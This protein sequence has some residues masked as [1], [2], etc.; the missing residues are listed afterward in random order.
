MPPKLVCSRT[1][2]ETVDVGIGDADLCV[3]MK[4]QVELSGAAVLRESGRSLQ[5]QRVCAR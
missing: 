3:V 5:G 1:L 2:E 4:R